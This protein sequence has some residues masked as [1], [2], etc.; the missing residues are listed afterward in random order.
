MFLFYKMQFWKWCT[1]E[2]V[3]PMMCSVFT[4]FPVKLI[5]VGHDSS[6]A[7]LRLVWPVCNSINDNEKD[8]FIN[9]E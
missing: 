8:N 2:I 4:R 6:E 7:K 3:V 9:N 1:S 5:N